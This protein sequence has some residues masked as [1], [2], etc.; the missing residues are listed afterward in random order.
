MTLEEKIKETVIEWDESGLKEICRVALERNEA[1]AAE[2]LKIIGKIMQYVGKQFEDEEIF[3]PELVGSA[4]VVKNTIDEILDPAIRESG[5]SK[6]TLGKIV[7]GTV[8]GDVHSIGKDLVGSFLFSNGFEVFNLGEEVPASEFVDKAE[9]IGAHIIGLSSLLTMSMG[10]Q[11]EV[12]DELKNRGL[13]DKYKV[14]LGGSPTSNEWAD[15]IG[16]DGWADDAI[17]AVALVKKLLGRD[18]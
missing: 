12:I 1:K 13:R 9:E 8:E 14:I 7:I 15:E 17:E 16:A 6:E 3:L 18:N 10:F 2:L 5:E 4:N 11:R